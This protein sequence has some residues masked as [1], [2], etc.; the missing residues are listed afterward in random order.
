M[1][2]R[3]SHQDIVKRALDAKA[4]NFAAIGKM[5]TELGPSVS[6]ADEPWEVFC[7]TMRWFIRFYIVHGP[8][9]P[10]E[11]LGALRGMGEKIQG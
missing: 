11:D 4:V 10:I 3:I 8:L 6:L 9:G 2:Q 5:V 1:S 7:G